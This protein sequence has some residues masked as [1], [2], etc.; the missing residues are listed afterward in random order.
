MAE[1]HTQQKALL[2][3]F[4]TRNAEK[5][6]SMESLTDAL[7]DDLGGEAPGKSTVYRLVNRLSEEGTVRRFAEEGSRRFLY[8]IVGGKSCQRHLHMKCTQCGRLVHMNDAQSQKIIE[9]IYGDSEFA[10]NREQT[11]LYGSCAECSK[12]EAN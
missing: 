8:Q 1:Y 7:K 11:T 2:L 4:L 12:R 5:S 6:F 10:V 9:Q 3:D